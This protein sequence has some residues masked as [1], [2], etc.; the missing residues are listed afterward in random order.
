MGTVN[1]KL[2]YTG[3]GF[4]AMEL[5]DNPD[6]IAHGEIIA[7]AE[8]DRPTIDCLESAHL[9]QRVEATV[10]TE[11]GTEFPVYCYIIEHL[12]PSAIRKDVCPS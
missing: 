4:P 7:L 9:Y 1:G 12:P 6:N 5:F 2:Y 8:A 11:V 3:W 10:S